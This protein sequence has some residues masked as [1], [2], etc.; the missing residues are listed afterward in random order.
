M[1]EVANAIPMEEAA[2]PK[3]IVDAHFFDRFGKFIRRIQFDTETIPNDFR[4]RSEIEKQAFDCP[5]N[6]GFSYIY[7][8]SSLKHP[9][10]FTFL[11]VR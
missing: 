5:T 11:L 6:E 9:E 10:K 2:D 7:S 1:T 3:T 8:A 4:I